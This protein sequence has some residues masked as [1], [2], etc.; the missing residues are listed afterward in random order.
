MTGSYY[1]HTKRGDVYISDQI[2]KNYIFLRIPGVISA[3][4]SKSLEDVLERYT[5]IAGLEK[6][7]LLYK[8]QAKDNIVLANSLLAFCGENSGIY[9]M[10]GAAIA[11][12]N[13]CVI[14]Q[15][16]SLAGKSRT[17]YELR[18]FYNIGGD[19]SILLK[20]LGQKLEFVGGNR[21]SYPKIW[22]DN[23]GY[24]NFGKTAAA[25]LEVVGII[26]LK[27]VYNPKDNKCIL[28][29]L[30]Y[31]NLQF[32]MWSWVSSNSR[33]V[34]GY[35]GEIEYPLPSLDTNEL[36][37]KRIKFCNEA[38]YV[39][40]YFYEGGINTLSN[41]ISMLLKEEDPLKKAIPYVHFKS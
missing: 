23:G 25:D 29:K 27:T 24:V 2:D 18:E 12:G 3:K 30:S 33:G 16:D 15:G 9:T 19:D 36:A 21:Y 5:K 22:H 13:K 20:I 39:P 6:E 17:A 1:V 28:Q 4:H 26:K 38:S 35:L 8:M 41:I 11:K 34:G 7:D 31:D 32:L 40:F 14:L 10:E 37:K